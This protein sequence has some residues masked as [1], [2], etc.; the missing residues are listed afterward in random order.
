MKLSTCNKDTMDAHAQHIQHHIRNDHV[1][2]TVR[3]GYSFNSPAIQLQFTNCCHFPKPAL[4][5]S[6]S[7][8]QVDL[9]GSI[10]QRS[11]LL[12]II[13]YNYYR[14]PWLND[15]LLLGDFIFVIGLG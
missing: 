9:E 1:Q 12:L 2:E 10:V 15:C 13:H 3:K 14:N 7:H 4:K 11:S 6:Q 8:V 5:K